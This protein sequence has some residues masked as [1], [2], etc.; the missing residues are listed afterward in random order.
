MPHP[1][2]GYRDAGLSG[3]I[4]DPGD[5]GSSGYSWTSAVSDILGRF[6]WF[7]TKALGTSHANRRA[8]GFQLRCLSE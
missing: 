5:V 6:L 1:A 7:D 2:P 3:R 4:G 8:Y